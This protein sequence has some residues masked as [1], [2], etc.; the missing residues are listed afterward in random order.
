MFG[1]VLCAVSLSACTNVSKSMINHHA[2]LSGVS[3][4]SQAEL[5]LLD[6]KSLCSSYAA[7]HD[8]KI[9]QEINSRHL[10][11]KDDW[12]LINSGKVKVG[13]SECAALADYTNKDECLN[14]KF[15]IINSKKTHQT[16]AETEYQCGKYTIITL[17]HRVDKIYHNAFNTSLIPLSIL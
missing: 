11:S 10:I 16:Q 8:E 5:K 3:N 9:K 4:Y 7:T 14:K 17:N 6:N 13:M 2:L 12:T 15:N 1:I